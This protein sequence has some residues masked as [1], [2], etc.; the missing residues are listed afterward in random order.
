MLL[1]L[2][3]MLSPGSFTDDRLNWWHTP[4]RSPFS[5]SVPNQ[6]HFRKIYTV[7]CT[8]VTRLP[9]NAVYYEKPQIK[10]KRRKKETLANFHLKW[11]Y[12]I[13]ITGFFLLMYV[14]PWYASVT[15]NSGTYRINQEFLTMVWKSIHGPNSLMIPPPL[16]PIQMLIV[17][18]VY[19]GDLPNWC[20]HLQ[21][22]GPL[23]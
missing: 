1:V 17:Q 20:Q 21:T 6:L 11:S 3:V 19:W 4:T 8:I 12:S 9:L 18:E 15:K 10:K 7:W 13:Y 5:K 23:L 16:S 2:P 14:K 22:Q